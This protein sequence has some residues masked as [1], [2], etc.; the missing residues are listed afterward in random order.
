MGKFLTARA[1]ERWIQSTALR[2]A[3][4]GKLSKDKIIEFNR[5]F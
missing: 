3:E 5:I 1:A 4:R 2:G